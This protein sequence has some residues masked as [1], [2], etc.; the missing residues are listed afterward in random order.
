MICKISPPPAEVHCIKNIIEIS[1]SQDLV[2]IGSLSAVSHLLSN[3]F[4]QK[5]NITTGI[6]GDPYELGQN[7]KYFLPMGGGSNIN[8]NKIA[9]AA[10]YDKT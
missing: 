10:R 1:T 4:D 6:R 5:W 2:F 9:P 7:I 3:H 8:N